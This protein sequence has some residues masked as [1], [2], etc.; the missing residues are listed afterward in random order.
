MILVVVAETD[1]DV[2]DVVAEILEAEGAQVR[3]A[4]S[5]DDLIRVLASAAFDALVVETELWRSGGLRLLEAIERR[6][7]AP[8]VVL[9]GDWPGDSEPPSDVRLIEKP[10]AAGSL[11]AAF[12]AALGARPSRSG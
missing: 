1:R 2:R 7:P 8:A 5:A 10:F 3:Q 11:V 6:Q 9:T 4:S 12:S